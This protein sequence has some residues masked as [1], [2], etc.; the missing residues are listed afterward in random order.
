MHTGEMEQ[1]SAT[2]HLEQFPAPFPCSPLSP[3]LS[4][5]SC[6]ISSAAVF[7]GPRHA[8]LGGDDLYPGVDLWP[9]S[10]LFSPLL[11]LPHLLRDQ[12]YFRLSLPGPQHLCLID[13]VHCCPTQPT[14]TCTHTHPLCFPPQIWLGAQETWS[15]WGAAFTGH[16]HWPRP[17][18]AA[19]ACSTSRR[20]GRSW[21]GLPPVPFAGRAAAPSLGAPAAARTAPAS[22]PEL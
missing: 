6:F 2:V 16:P 3:F 15:R 14:R 10:M 7:Q 4:L 12:V 22:C 20:R 19:P 8:Y 17:S 11:R 1:V 5:A 18:S 13:S 9:F 21:G